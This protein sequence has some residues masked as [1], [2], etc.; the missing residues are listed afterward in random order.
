MKITLDISMY[1]LM[2]AYESSILS[3]IEHLHHQ[4]GV[5]VKVNALS[6]QV[7]GEWDDVFTAVKGGVTQYLAAHRGSFVMKV[8]H[9]DI[10]LDYQYSGGQ[11]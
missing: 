9:G 11:E 5:L 1:P 6:T 10:D 3:F 8:L 2:E 4:Q 7:Q